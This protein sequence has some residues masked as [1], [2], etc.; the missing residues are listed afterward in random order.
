MVDLEIL[1]KTQKKWQWKTWPGFASLFSLRFSPSKKSNS[2]QTFTKNEEQNRNALGR[3]KKKNDGHTSR[4]PR[5]LPETTPTFGESNYCCFCSQI[6]FSNLFIYLFILYLFIYLFI[7]FRFN[8]SKLQN[9]GTQQLA[10]YNTV[11]L[12]EVLVWQL[13]SSGYTISCSYTVT[14]N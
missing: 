9:V 13:A 6:Y 1:C 8:F 4:N 2:K 11:E 12:H 7:H 3:N 14:I 5:A 10:S